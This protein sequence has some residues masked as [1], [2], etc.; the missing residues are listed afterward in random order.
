MRLLGFYMILKSSKEKNNPKRYVMIL[1]I[2]GKLLASLFAWPKSFGIWQECCSW[3]WLLNV[4]RS[5]QVAELG[6]I[7]LCQ[8]C[9][10]QVHQGSLHCQGGWCR[11]CHALLPWWSES[12]HFC[13]GKSLTMSWH[14]C[15]PMEKWAH[16]EGKILTMTCWWK[17][18]KGVIQ[19]TPVVY[20]HYKYQHN[21]DD[22]N[23]K[24]HSPISLESTWSMKWWE[25]FG[26]SF[27]LAFNEVNYIL[28]Y[29]FS[30]RNQ[31]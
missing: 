8:I 17:I 21:I 16:E 23:A 12:I 13:N 27:S 10:H 5:F 9:W 1:M 19:I 4:K 24:R 14:W 28:A 20:N 18:G 7:C 29:S 6:N 11:R 30:T 15:Q 26:F 31:R 22:N 3:Q 2:W 25:C